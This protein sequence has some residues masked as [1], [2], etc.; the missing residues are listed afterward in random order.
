[1]RRKRIRT[2]GGRVVEEEYVEERKREDRKWGYTKG[3]TKR[4]KEMENKNVTR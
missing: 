3:G 2:K 4:Y 1:L